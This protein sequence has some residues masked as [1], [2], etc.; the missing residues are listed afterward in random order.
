MLSDDSSSVAKYQSDQLDAISLTT[1]SSSIVNYLSAAHGFKSERVIRLLK[2]D[3][4]NRTVIKNTRHKLCSMCWRL[5]GFPAKKT[6]IKEEHEQI[7]G[8]ANC[9]SCVQSYAFTSSY[10]TRIFNVDSYAQKLSSSTREKFSSARVSKFT[11]VAKS[12]NKFP[13][14]SRRF[15]VKYNDDEQA[16]SDYLHREPL[17]N[18][19]IK[20]IGTNNE[21]TRNLPRASIQNALQQS[22]RTI[23][24]KTNTWL[25]SGTRAMIGLEDYDKELTEN[26]ELNPNII[27]CEPFGKSQLLMY[28]T[29][30]DRFIDKIISQMQQL[31]AFSRIPIVILLMQGD[32]SSVTDI[33]E[34]ITKSIPTII[35]KGTGLIANQ[36][37]AICEQ[38][39]SEFKTTRSELSTEQLLSELD[40]RTFSHIK[41]NKN[42]LIF[43][44]Q[45]G[46]D[47]LDESILRA[48]SSAI[49]I[50]DSSHAHVI[51]LSFAIRFNRIKYTQKHILNYN[52]I[53]NWTNNELDIC[54]EIAILS[55][56][57]SFVELLFQYGASLQRLALIGNFDLFQITSDKKKSYAT[58]LLVES[59]P[60][61][62]HLDRNKRIRMY[63]RL[64]FCWA[65]D[66]EYFDLVLSICTRLEDSIT[67]M[68]LVS[69]WCQYKAEHD[70]TTSD[71]YRKYRR[72]FQVYAADIL[73]LYYADNEEET[74]EFLNEKSILYQD[75]EPSVLIDDLCSKALVSTKCIQS[76]ANTVWY[77]KQFHRNKNFLWDILVC[78]VCLLPLV[79]LIPSIRNRV[80]QWDEIEKIEEPKR[81]FRSKI[82]KLCEPFNRFYYGNA[83]VR[84]RYNMA[85]Y[86]AFLILFSYTILFDY[87]P[88]NIYN[89][90]RS[91]IYGLPIPLTELILHIFLLSIAV[92]EIQQV[93]LHVKS[94]LVKSPFWKRLDGM[95]RHRNTIWSF[96][97]NDPWN[98]LDLVAFT[99]WLIGF[100][101]R[102]IVKD[103]VFA[104][105][106]I[107]M[108][109]DLC[110]WYIRCLHIF[111]ASQVLGPKLLM[112]FHTM[113]DLVLFL[114][115]IF[116]F[117]LAYTITTYSLISTSS[118]VIW[119]NSTYFTTLQGGG[120]MTNL[121]N[122]RNIIEWGTWKI[123]GSTSLETSASVAMKYSAQNDAYGFVTLILTITFIIIAYVLL[124]NNLIAL[125]NFTIQR[126]H[127][128][129]R[130]AWC[131][132]FYVVLKEYEEKQMFVPP[133][134]L[135]L[136]PI[137][138]LI[139]RKSH[140]N[141]KKSPFAENNHY[142]I[143]HI[144]RR[145]QRISEKYWKDKQISDNGFANQRIYI[146][147]QC[148]CCGP[149]TGDTYSTFL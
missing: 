67:A 1:A 148:K 75:Q 127:G 94:V 10:R 139:R 6:H 123:F 63:L 145:Q 120:N 18:L 51:E 56:A 112:I 54:L 17:P 29:T 143:A 68:L 113:K 114:L 35:L 26:N 23:M 66:N 12:L 146:S 103:Y 101:T 84:F 49:R 39:G 44:C 104:I 22:I 96:Y 133:F 30:A 45:P 118:M 147:C 91:N 53:I 115:F 130:Q 41:N 21:Q 107:F 50:I 34:N 14:N 129:S 128:E 138:C 36:L 111:L 131:Y 62:T 27:T 80:L 137:N 47:E 99:F 46:R 59:I 16:F 72:Q 13:T 9:Q 92:E 78:L 95:K 73:D 28:H 74:I 2:K 105:S 7:P 69:Q 149:E 121:E 106:K 52:T 5:L 98:V 77:G 40:F 19:I 32:T 8:F 24:E 31:E 3:P 48:I 55:N 134:N 126:V 71:K 87:F 37:A 93:I 43:V 81:N 88:L 38:T 144:R 83:C 57:V 86:A 125:F 85:S 20:I 42:R 79:L 100:I 102:F 108:S 124:L 122:L 110:F 65:V 70:T 116:I 132:H 97:N 135:F 64:V 76:Y 142:D 89:E 60:A 119:A 117:H 25:L 141:R 82:R 11:L 61:V 136:W 140:D 4:S 90:Q 33:I 15:N 109:L 58:E